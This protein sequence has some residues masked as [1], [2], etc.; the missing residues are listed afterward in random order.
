MGKHLSHFEKH[1]VA[2][3]VFLAGPIP[4][5]GFWVK[6]DPVYESFKWGFFWHNNKATHPLKVIPAHDG[7]QSEDGLQ[8]SSPCFSPNHWAT[9]S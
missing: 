2:P 6:H 4:A 3:G 9:E 5:A 7:P 8:M 1:G